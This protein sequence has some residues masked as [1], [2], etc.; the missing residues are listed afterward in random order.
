MVASSKKEYSFVDVAAVLLP[1]VAADG[2][3]ET[4]TVDAD[5]GDKNNESDDIDDDDVVVLDPSVEEDEDDASVKLSLSHMNIFILR[6]SSLW[7][8]IIRGVANNPSACAVDGC[9]FDMTCCMSSM[10]TTAVIENS[11]TIVEAGGCELML[12]LCRHRRRRR[13]WLTQL[14]DNI[15]EEIKARRSP[16]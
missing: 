15:E 2:M 9:L 14:V 3:D 6:I 4:A 11:S 10:V 13:C 7:S 5:A 1:K 16:Q 8:F 12:L